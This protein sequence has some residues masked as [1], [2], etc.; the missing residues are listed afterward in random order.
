MKAARCI[1]CDSNNLKPSHQIKFENN[2]YLYDFCNNCN[3]TFQNPWPTREIESIYNDKKYWNSSNVYNEK[4]VEKISENNYAN[5]QNTRFKEAKERYIKLKKFLTNS[6]GSIL[7]IGCANGIFL[8]EWKKNGWKCLG[9]DPAKDMIDYGIKNFNLDLKSENWEQL[10]LEP[11]TQDCIYMWGT[12]GNFYD[13]NLGF[14]KINKSL[15][16]N[17]IYALTYQDFKHP[18]R[19][20]FK[21]IKMQHNALYNFSKKSI[22][23]LMDKLGFKVLEHSMTWQNT[24]LS[25]VK[26]ILGLNTKGIDFSF[27]V[28]A[29]SYNLLIV[30]KIRNI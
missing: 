12:D 25:H 5:Y 8:N 26:K 7:E 20:V 15:K 30:Q 28:P 24:K 3:F 9:V 29:I 23:Y 19:K 1:L 14:E 4:N 10:D 27:K 6:N 2:N 16:V 21:Q 17:G 11:N 22:F 13:F 18:I